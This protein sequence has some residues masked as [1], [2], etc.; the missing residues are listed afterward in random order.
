VVKLHCSG[1]MAYKFA[2]A[3]IFSSFLMILER[4][5]VGLFENYG[6]F[7]EFQLGFGFRKLKPC[8]NGKNPSY[9]SQN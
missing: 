6:S 4:T 1:N 5:Y 8:F 3:S 2:I 7:Q 9:V